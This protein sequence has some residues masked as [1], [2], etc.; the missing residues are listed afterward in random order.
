LKALARGARR[1]AQVLLT[2]RGATM[3]A[4]PG[5]WVVPG[6]HVDPAESLEAAAARAVRGRARARA[7]PLR[8]RAARAERRA[9][10]SQVFEETGVVVRA[11]ALQALGAW[12]SNYPHRLALGAPQRQHV[13]V[14]FAGAAEAAGRARVGPAGGA[15]DA[16]ELQATMQEVE[17]DAVASPPC[18]A[19][20]VPNG[21][22][23][24]RARVLTG[25][26]AS[27]APVPTG[28]AAS[29]A[30][31]L[32]GRA[33][34]PQVAWVPPDGAALLARGARPALAA[35]GA[36]RVQVPGSGAG[37]GVRVEPLALAAV[38]EPPSLPY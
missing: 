12:E 18:P 38:G 7:A 25:H 16:G 37:G 11:E 1:A 24:S 23:A 4:F 8:G 14:Y 19:L 3:R 21:R 17:V 30:R 13:V 28:H 22:A 33:N 36:L 2:R 26:A 6:G 20:S 10:H 31:V 32:T 35:A 9:R 5:V 29:R 27:R 34:A 15:D